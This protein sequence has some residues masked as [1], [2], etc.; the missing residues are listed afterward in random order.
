VPLI[1]RL[2]TPPPPGGSIR[3]ALERFTETFVN[4][5]VTTRRG[6]I[7][8]LIVAEGSRFPDIADFYYREVVSR[9]MAGISM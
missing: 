7:V 5:V 2:A 4:E 9:G 3:A 8:R 6:D 1:N